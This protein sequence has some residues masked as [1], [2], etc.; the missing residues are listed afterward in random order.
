[1]IFNYTRLEG[2]IKRS[3]LSVCSWLFW[4]FFELKEKSSTRNYRA[5]LAFLDI[6]YIKLLP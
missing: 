2:K 1:M 4:T 5:V 6:S 3:Q